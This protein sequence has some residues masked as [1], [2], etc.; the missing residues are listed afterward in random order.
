MKRV[1]VLLLL[2]SS[3]QVFSQ[4]MPVDAIE[5][6]GGYLYY[7]LNNEKY[8]GTYRNSPNIG[9]SLMLTNPIAKNLYYHVG[10]NYS[11]KN[12]YWENNLDKED[13]FYKRIET[14]L[15]HLKLPFL[16]S[17]QYAQLGRLSLNIVNGLV[18]N[19]RIDHDVKR[20]YDGQYYE[21][22]NLKPYANIFGVSYEIGHIFNYKIMPDVTVTL[23]P[24]YGYKFI[25]DKSRDYR[26]GIAHL[27]DDRSYVT[28]MFGIKYYFNNYP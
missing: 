28:I 3:I 13:P 9:F 8:T 20:Q 15:K 14:Y 1:V 19:A 18:L 22:N 21:D 10:F 25:L 16:L 6:Q 23:T 11:T 2:M 4:K 27:L 7:F 12:F 5:I 24:T 26:T 17:Y